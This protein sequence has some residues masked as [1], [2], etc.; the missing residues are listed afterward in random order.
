MKLW[1]INCMEDKFPGMWQ[2]WFKNQC[3]GVGWYSGWNYRLTGG[4]Q[5]PGWSRARNAIQEVANG[6]WVIVA[7]RGHRIGRV[8]EVTGKAISDDE[9]DWN[10]LVP[11]SKGYPDGEIGRRIF[12]RWDLLTGPDDR[13][14]IIKLP[15]GSRLT[16]GELRPTIC[17]IQSH[18]LQK[19]RRVMNDPANWVGLDTHFDYE[20]ALQG[21][22]AAY[23]HELEDGLLP[24][25]DIKV[26]EKIFRDSTRSDVLLIDRHERP[27]VVECKQG[28]P[29]IDDIAQLRHYMRHLARETD[30][31]PRGIL[32]H[33]G[34]LNLAENVRRAAAKKPKVEVIRYALKVDFDR[35]R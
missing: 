12:V 28:P 23:P 9:K 32:V 3:V 29:T 18:S 11:E 25:P 5:N 19:F 33:G 35:S 24:H 10:P 15:H 6:D 13:D 17:E 7:L 31:K 4:K 22:I 2:R 16:P 30:H 1:K 26:R 8:G 27:V 21:Y 20:S 14:L 34:A